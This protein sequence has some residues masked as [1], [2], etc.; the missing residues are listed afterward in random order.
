MFG[1][2]IGSH[3]EWSRA[4]VTKINPEFIRAS[5][6]QKLFLNFRWVSC[7]LNAW[8]K[9]LSSN[10]WLYLDFCYIS[11]FRIGFSFIIWITD[12]PQQTGWITAYSHHDYT[13]TSYG[14]LPHVHQINN[15]VWRTSECL[16]VCLSVCLSACLCAHAL[17]CCVCVYCTCSGFM[18]VIIMWCHHTVQVAYHGTP[19]KAYEVFITALK[20]QYLEKGLVLPELEDQNPA[21]IISFVC[22]CAVAIKVVPCDDA[23]ATISMWQ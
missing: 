6:H 19:V 21:G 14:D 20:A 4:H 5:C 8:Q 23:H 22:I 3:F 7:N 12:I 10:L 18:R 9:S 15:V 16:S 11:V 17:L 2:F 1:S 13:S